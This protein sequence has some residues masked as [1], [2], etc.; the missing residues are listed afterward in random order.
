MADKSPLLEELA[1]ESR[2]D[3][4]LASTIPQWFAY[5]VEWVDFAVQSKD[6]LGITQRLR[7]AMTKTKPTDRLAWTLK[8]ALLDTGPVKSECEAR[9]SGQVAAVSP[10]NA[11]DAAALADSPYSLVHLLAH[12]DG[13]VT[14]AEDEQ[15]ASRRVQ[16]KRD[17]DAAKMKTV[18]GVLEQWQS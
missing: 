10:G 2:G 4:R 5:L 8:S 16:S 13:Y 14:R 1:P 18:L 7:V 3:P 9:A 15:E 11:K 12:S 6:Y 17:T